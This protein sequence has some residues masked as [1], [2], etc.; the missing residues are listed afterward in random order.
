ME[1]LSKAHTILERRFME[2]R[3]FGVDEHGEKIRDITG[4][5]VR[6]NVEHLEECIS[7]KTGPEGGKVAVDELCRLLNERIPVLSTM[8]VRHS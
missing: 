7:R 8:S 4:M 1:L 3:P 2:F 6:A 5:I